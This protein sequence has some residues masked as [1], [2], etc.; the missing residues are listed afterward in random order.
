MYCSAM[1]RNPELKPFL[2]Q[3][4][5]LPLIIPSPPKLSSSIFGFVDTCATRKQPSPLPAK[6]RVHA[7]TPGML[8]TRAAYRT[9]DGSRWA[10]KRKR[11]AAPTHPRGVVRANARYHTEIRSVSVSYHL[12]LASQPLKGLLTQARSTRKPKSG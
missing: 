7:V 5:S 12:D 4:T 1:C 2:S 9:R 3:L 8:R 11:R 6:S 10:P